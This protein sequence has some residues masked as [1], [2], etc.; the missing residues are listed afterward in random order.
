MSTYKKTVQLT[1]YVEVEAEIHVVRD[2]NYGAD[3]DGNRGITTYEVDGVKI[4]NMDEI[5]AS[6][7]NQ[8]CENADLTEEDGRDPDEGRDEK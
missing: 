8:V 1:C 4:L 6:L 7:E 5:Q 3:A 2:P